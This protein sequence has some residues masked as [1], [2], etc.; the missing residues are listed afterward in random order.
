MDL[1]AA[2]GLLGSASHTQEYRGRDGIVRIT[3]PVYSITVPSEYRKDCESLVQE[4]NRREFVTF[5]TPLITVG[6]CTRDWAVGYASRNVSTSK[7]AMLTYRS[8]GQEYTPAHD[9]PPAH[10]YHTRGQLMGPAQLRPEDRREA[11]S[12]LPAAF[13]ILSAAIL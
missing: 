2:L 5:S 11:L 7:S 8:L 1:K 9:Y 3:P 10:E 4:I 12:Q 13:A 6:V